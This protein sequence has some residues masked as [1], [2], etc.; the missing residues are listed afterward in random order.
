MGPVVPARSETRTGTGDVGGRA[1]SLGGGSAA[2]GVSGD[3]GVRSW[4]VRSSELDSA[5]GSIAG[6]AD[7][8]CRWCPFRRDVPSGIWA[9]EEYAKLA[10]RD[11]E[12]VYQP[13]EIFACHLYGKGERRRYCAGA[14]GC[15]DADHLLALRVGLMNGEITP[16]VADQ[17]RTYV[18]PVPLFSTGVEAALHGMAEITNT[19]TEARAAMDKLNKIIQLRDGHHAGEAFPGPAPAM[20]TEANAA[21]RCRWCDGTKARCRVCHEPRHGQDA[22][23]EPA[24]LPCRGCN[25]GAYP[26]RPHDGTPD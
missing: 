19:S 21:G 2:G 24:L 12:T 15:Y 26:V 8:P 1:T 14:A 3:E 7:Q 13:V 23:H 20:Y 17:I 11:V 18:S 22:D 5:A 25:G 10:A 9:P 6:P 4:G 16:E